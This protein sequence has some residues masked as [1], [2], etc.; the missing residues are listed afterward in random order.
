MEKDLLALKTFN[1][2]PPWKESCTWVRKDKKKGH[3]WQKKSSYEASLWSIFIDPNYLVMGLQRDHE[4]KFCVKPWVKSLPPIWGELMCF[5]P[6]HPPHTLWWSQPTSVFPNLQILR[7]RSSLKYL[8]EH[9]FCLWQNELKLLLLVFFFVCFFNGFSLMQGTPITSKM[10]SPLFHFSLT[11]CYAIRAKSL[12][13]WLQ[14][15]LDQN[16]FFVC[17]R[18]KPPQLVTLLKPVLGPIHIQPWLVYRRELYCTSWIKTSFCCCKL[19]RSY[20]LAGWEKLP[21]FKYHLGQSNMECLS[22]FVSWECCTFS[23]CD[24]SP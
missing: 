14:W 23:L 19:I 11:C 3:S 20:R 18:T 21:W 15:T 7:L 12:G 22:L 6:C 1:L 10:S 16:L 24:I 2:W 13:T 9:I 5:S 17:Q 8:G 4:L